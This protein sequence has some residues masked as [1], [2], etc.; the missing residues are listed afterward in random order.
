MLVRS[1]IS[2]AIIAP[3]HSKHILFGEALTPDIK[4]YLIHL[5]LWEEFLKDEHLESS[6]NL[7]SWG[8]RKIRENNFLYHPNSCGWHIERRKFNQM[9]ICACKREGVLY[10]NSKIETINKNPDNK[11]SF[12]LK[13]KNDIVRDVTAEFIIDASGR[14]GLYT[15]RQGIRRLVFDKL[16][17]FVCFLC[18]DIRDRDSFTSIE[19]VSNGWFYTAQ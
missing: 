11:F 7:S 13:N 12:K 3:L 17:A 18:P 8:E 14:A 15:S 19:S 6:G 9:F 4:T 10:L 2:T 5:H 16:C 1:G